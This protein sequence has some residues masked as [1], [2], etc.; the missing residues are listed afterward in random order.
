[1]FAQVSSRK[2][3]APHVTRDKTKG[4]PRAIAVERSDKPPP[5]VGGI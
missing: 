2:Q 1:M 3:D 5:L 4:P